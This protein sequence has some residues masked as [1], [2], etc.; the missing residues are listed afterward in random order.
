[1]N[2]ITADAGTCP[3]AS[4]AGILK[5]DFDAN[6]TKIPLP[7][8]RIL[9]SSPAHHQT[10]DVSSRF[11]MADARSGWPQGLNQP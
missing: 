6:A 3:E 9:G 11:F 10:D 4:C 7:F 5:A 8:C 2:Q 1:V